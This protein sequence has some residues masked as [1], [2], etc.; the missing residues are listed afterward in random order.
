MRV[1]TKHQRL[2]HSGFTL[3][4]LLVVMAVIAILAALLLP[5]LA[6]GKSAAQSAACKSN[7]RQLGTALNMY[8]ADYDKYPGNAVMY[9]GGEF[10]AIWATGMNWLN[11]YIG[12]KYD[13]SAI[14][15]RLFRIPTTPTVFNCP[16]IKPRY[17]PGLMGQ[18]GQTFYDLAYGYNELGTGWKRSNPQLGLGFAV[19]VTG[20]ADGGVGQPL[21]LRNYVHS[22]DV[23]VPS[24]MIAIGDGANWL[25]P[26][27]RPDAVEG[28]G[29]VMAHHSGFA[30]MAFSDG[31]S[32]TAKKG[33]WVEE[34]EEARK[35]WNNDHQPH[36][37]TW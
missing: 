21:G 7:L 3:V 36:P 14:N 1:P 29:S 4:E 26:N 28:A 35:R 25:F 16:A 34:S 15:D 32:E 24:D 20:F 11:P 18:P 6:K 2:V 23:K 27:L 12:G 13:P 17:V 33:G 8:V 30:N 19:E 9:S 22:A 31:H 5:A 10:S 37:E